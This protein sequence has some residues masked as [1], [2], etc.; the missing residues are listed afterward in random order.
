[1]RKL[2]KKGFTLVEIMI[3]VAIIGLLAA[4]AIPNFVNARVVARTN[5][6][7]ANQRTI[8]GALT[9]AN[10]EGVTTASL[11]NI[12][13]IQTAL[14]PTYMVSVPACPEGSAYTTTAAGVIACANAAH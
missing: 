3:V 4:I 11:A 9:L 14:V 12:G 2:D 10:F 8:Q 5:T 13:A 1:M 7:Q 6:C